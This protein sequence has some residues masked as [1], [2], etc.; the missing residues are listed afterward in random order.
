MSNLKLTAYYMSLLLCI[1]YNEGIV[2]VW[3]H[4]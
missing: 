2:W 4:Q 3:Y 1:S